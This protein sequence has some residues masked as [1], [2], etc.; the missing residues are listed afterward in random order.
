MMIEN[1]NSNSAGICNDG[2]GGFNTIFGSSINGN[3][4]NW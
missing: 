3:I 2:D 4:C 1:Y